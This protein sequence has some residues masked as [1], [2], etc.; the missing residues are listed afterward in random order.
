MADCWA[1]EHAVCP[2]LH[3]LLV[4][5]VAAGETTVFAWG[6]SSA[7]VSTHSRTLS[8]YHSA[9]LTDL[10][11]PPVL[12]VSAQQTRDIKPMLVQCWSGVVDGGTTLNQ[13]WFNASCL[14]GFDLF[15]STLN[16]IAN[17]QPHAFL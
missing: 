12:P 11:L 6:T 8:L 10:A 4:L 9:V 15:A 2:A 17:F 3:H 13:H 14:L 5:V 1:S 16:N 7:R